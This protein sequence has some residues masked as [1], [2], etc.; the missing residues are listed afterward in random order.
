MEDGTK[1]KNNRENIAIAIRYVK[2]GTVN[3]SLLTVTT[4]VNLDAATFT[5]LTLNTLTENN[6]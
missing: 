2:D 3:E 5:E 4:T 6:I 1:D